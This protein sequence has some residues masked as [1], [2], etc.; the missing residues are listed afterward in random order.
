MWQKVGGMSKL[1]NHAFSQEKIYSEEDIV[2]YLES[3]MS[4]VMCGDYLSDV[5]WGVEKNENLYIAIFGI[6]DGVLD[7]RLSK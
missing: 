2:N 6:K 3:F 1:F 5:P 4:G 7:K